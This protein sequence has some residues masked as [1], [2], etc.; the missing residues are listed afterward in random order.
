MV[1]ESEVP[2]TQLVEQLRR[3]METRP[4]IDQAHGVLMATHG[5]TPEE[6]WA[7]LKGASQ[8]TN[9][10]LH[11]VAEEVVDSTQHIPM[12]KAIRVGKA[13]RA[14]IRAELRTLNKPSS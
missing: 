13:I 9:T 1:S 14:A 2:E 11:E 12:G 5:C 3:A 4:V 7:V 8:N 6:A 10:K